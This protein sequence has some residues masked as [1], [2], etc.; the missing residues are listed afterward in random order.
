MGPDISIWHVICL[1]DWDLRPQRAVL[2]SE[3][4]M[5]THRGRPRTVKS[6]KQRRAS[7]SLRTIRLAPGVRVDGSGEH[8]ALFVLMSAD[9][10][11]Q[12]NHAASAVLKLCDGSRD[13]DTIVAEL[14]RGSDRQA[15]AGEIVEFLDAAFARGWIVDE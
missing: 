15:L 6:T 13:R 7:P 10:K 8:K 1:S 3:R 5:S 2:S 11:V 9:G 12:L 14:T 4:I